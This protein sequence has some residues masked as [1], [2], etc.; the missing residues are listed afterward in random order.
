MLKQTKR[1]AD[2][3][4]FMFFKKEKLLAQTNYQSKQK[5]KSQMIKRKAK[6]FLTTSGLS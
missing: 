6:T 3:E 1:S 2:F 5:K 4:E